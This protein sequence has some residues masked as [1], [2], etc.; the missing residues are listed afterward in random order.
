MIEGS[1]DLKFSGDASNFHLGGGYNPGVLNWSSLQTLL[2]YFDRRN[3][4]NLEIPHNSPPDSL[5]VC[6][7]SNILGA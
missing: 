5:P 3:D 4:Q 7:T 2:T 6:F 1:S